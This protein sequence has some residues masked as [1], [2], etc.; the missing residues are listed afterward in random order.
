MPGDSRRIRGPE[1]SRCPLLYASP[2]A[3]EPPQQARTEPR[4]LYARAGLLSQAK[5]SAY[6]ETGGGGGTKVL[7]G[8]SGPREAERRDGPGIRGARLVCEVRWA[9]FARLG[10][11]CGLGTSLEREL[12]LALQESLEPAVRLERYPRAQIHVWVLVLEDR[13]SAFASALSAAS[14]ALADAGIEMYD[15]VVG[16]ALSRGPGGSLLL[17][18]CDR[19]E[20]RPR[21]CG[22]LTLALMPALNQVCG[23]LCNGEWTEESM[24]QAVRLCMEGCHRLYPVLQQCL[25]RATKRKIS[26]PLPV[27]T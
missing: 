23:L 3:S 24:S 20:A 15:V 10:A 14:L 9:P 17:D 27:S 19:D 8:A 11:R 22:C 7:S 2:E 5:G 25:V 1:E 13:G 18:P 4:P 12:S 26:V 16:C 21:S 6:I